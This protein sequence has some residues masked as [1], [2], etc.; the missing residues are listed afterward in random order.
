MNAQQAMYEG[1]LALPIEHQ[2]FS[3]IVTLREILTD[4]LITVWIDEE[5]FSG[6]RPWGNSSWQY[7]I[8]EALAYHSYPTDAQF[9]R[10]LI[11]YMTSKEA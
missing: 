6:K 9:F 3:K 1:A 8:T 11:R 10:G 2:D 4:L 7:D 5:G